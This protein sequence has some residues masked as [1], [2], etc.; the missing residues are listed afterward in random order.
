MPKSALLSLAA[1]SSALVLTACSTTHSC[2]FCPATPAAASMCWED[3]VDLVGFTQPGLAQPNL[4]IHVARM[5]HTPAGSAPSGMI[6]YQPDPKAAPAIAG[7]VSSDA[8][9]GAYFGPQIFAG[10]PFEKAPVIVG[11]IRIDTSVAGQASSVVTVDGFVFE[12]TLSG[13]GA[14]AV[15]SH[16]KG[17]PMPFAQKAQEKAATSAKVR[18]NG[19]EVPVTVVPGTVYSA[20]GNYSR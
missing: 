19:K 5:V 2:D 14:Q 11:T 6:L 13:F 3:G 20:H 16:A 17:D 12:T 10:T 8:N 9:V 7:F 18:I 4:I 15:N 1:L